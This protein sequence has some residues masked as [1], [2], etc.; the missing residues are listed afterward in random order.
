MKPRNLRVGP[1]H[2]FALIH[3]VPERKGGRKSREFTCGRREGV[4]RV[5]QAG[6]RPRGTNT[7]PFIEHRARG[8]HVVHTYLLFPRMVKLSGNGG[9]VDLLPRTHHLALYAQG[10]GL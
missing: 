3:M 9:C 5:H 1:L 7:Y 10:H 8:G 2:D 6:T 4:R